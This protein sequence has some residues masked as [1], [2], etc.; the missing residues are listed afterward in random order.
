MAKSKELENWITQIDYSIQIR[1]KYIKSWKYWQ[2]MF[3]DNLW[4]VS[5]F[6]SGRRLARDQ[7]NEIIPQSNELEQVVLAILPNLIQ[8]EPV[9]QFVPLSE[10]YRFSAAVY[11]L[12][13]SILYD[14]YNIDE[15]LEDCCMDALILGT[16]IHKTG[17][18]SRHDFRGNVDD[19]KE[20]SVGSLFDISGDLLS[21][22]IDPIDTLWDSYGHDWESK[23]WFAHEVLRPL[24]AV[25]HST[26]YEHTNGLQANATLD[27]VY[28]VKSKT[29]AEL[30]NDTDF[31]NLVRL[32]EIHDLENEQLITICQ[33]HDKI[34][35]KDEGLDM[36]LFTPLSF[37]KTRPR[38]FWGKSIAQSIEEHVFRISKSYHYMDSY[39]RR[40]GLTKVGFDP[41]VV[42]KQSQAKLTSNTMFEKVPLPGI[43]EGKTPV[44]EIKF[45]GMQTDWYSMLNIQQQQIRSQSG[46]PM[47]ARGLHEPGVETAYE[48]AKLMEASDARNAFRLK[49]INTF[50][51]RITSKMLTIVSNNWTREQIMDIVGL[52]KNYGAFLLPF[53]NIKVNVKYGST[54]LAYRQQKTQQVMMLAQLLSQM[55]IQ[56]NP[57]GFVKLV[58]SNIGLDIK[59]NMLL[60][61]G[62]GTGIANVPPTQI[63]SPTGNPGNAGGNKMS[64]MLGG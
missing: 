25:K 19:E 35:R 30:K 53:N 9:Y 41:A 20:E 55:G 62:Q 59:E 29:S 39:M 2:E 63:S 52:D 13:A 26:M 50:I 24:Y 49:K 7:N 4:M 54:A 36:E 27:D 48:V 18:V 1:S 33:N 45:S 15:A 10:P 61:G 38:R 31:R 37:V 64:A 21:K 58:S 6:N 12:L 60:L 56:I 28:G 44:Q 34:L 43:A 51:E 32:V 5:S 8:F 46:V 3:D 23:R 57:E 42:D 40:A 11:E 47:Q 17:I 22:D 16:G 14:V